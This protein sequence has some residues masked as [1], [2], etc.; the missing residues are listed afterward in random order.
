M[1]IPKTNIVR[2]PPPHGHDSPGYSPAAQTARAASL[3][4][5]GRCDCGEAKLVSP[6][7]A[8]L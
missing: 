6:R 4:A 2:E 7:I 5:L 8:A 3:D 1:A